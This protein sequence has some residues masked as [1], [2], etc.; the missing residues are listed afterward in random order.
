[1]VRVNFSDEAP[2]VIKED[3]EYPDWVFKLSEKVSAEMHLA[4][5]LILLFYLRGLHLNVV[6]HFYKYSPLPNNGPISLYFQ[7]LLFFASTFT[8]A[9]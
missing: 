4:L 1:M 9:Q 6:L 3:K 2:I 7:R 8:V 5:F